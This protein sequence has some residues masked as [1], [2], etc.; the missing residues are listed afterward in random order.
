MLEAESARPTS[1]QNDRQNPADVPKSDMRILNAVDDR[2]G[3][4]APNRH[5]TG[6]RGVTASHPKRTTGKQSAEIRADWQPNDC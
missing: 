2:L 3:S 1:S 5:T 4:L 6:G